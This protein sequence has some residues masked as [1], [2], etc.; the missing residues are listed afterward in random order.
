MDGGYPDGGEQQR[1]GDEAQ[2]FSPLLCESY[3]TEST[4]NSSSE[5]KGEEVSPNERLLAQAG[6]YATNPLGSVIPLIDHRTIL[7]RSTTLPPHRTSSSYPMDKSEMIEKVIRAPMV[8]IPRYLRTNDGKVR[9]EGLQKIMSRLL[10]NDLG[11]NEKKF[12]L[13]ANQMY[14]YGCPSFGV[15][16][17]CLKKM[18]KRCV[19]QNSNISP[20]C[21]I[22]PNSLLKQYKEIHDP[23]GK[24]EF[25]FNQYIGRKIPAQTLSFQFFCQRCENAA[26]KEEQFLVGLY[27]QIMGAK[28]DYRLRL[29]SNDAEKL[30]HIL[31]VIMFRGMLLGVDFFEETPKE[32]FDD[33]FTTLFKLREFC[34]TFD[35][36]RYSD[37]PISKRIQVFLLPNAHFNAG[38]ID[39]TY[40]LD[41]Q[42]RN[43][44]FTTV[45][46]Q[47]G[48]KEAYLY[49]KFDCFHWVL[50]VHESYG[51]FLNQSSCFIIPEENGYCLPRRA[52]GVSL[53]PRFLVNYNIHQIGNLIQV[54]GSDE[55]RKAFGSHETSVC[56]IQDLKRGMNIWHTPP[57]QETEDK[58]EIIVDVDKIDITKMTGK[59]ITEAKK[60][61]P[62]AESMKNMSKY[63]EASRREIKALEE[64]YS[65]D[66]EKW[67]RKNTELRQENDRMKHEYH[68]LKQDY[69]CLLKKQ[70]Q[71]HSSL[72]N[73]EDEEQ[74]YPINDAR[75]MSPTIPVSAPIV[76]H[77]SLNSGWSSSVVGKYYS[78]LV[79]IDRVVG[80]VAI[81]SR[82]TS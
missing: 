65:K 30:K 5:T 54:F 76:S 15:C 40:I 69:E 3:F 77:I 63:L 73:Q 2:K 17:I 36:P 28:D 4:G 53:F 8:T 34:D 61:S 72:D 47:K 19:S 21:H 64:R 75:G 14:R 56:V 6:Q 42:L 82:P 45:I 12:F 46:N 78:S 66:K 16:S 29:S 74:D 35:S 32:Y 43:P 25:I 18:G 60:K 20:R 67:V 48:T 33:L 50:P 51:N 49:T 10:H 22:F 81:S 52:E 31:A 71:P 59:L 27:L 37:S 9:V 7:E 26:S 24:N 55:Y 58:N 39:P 44:L 41:L 62:I 38:N 13:F 70:S 68:Q 11:Q 1:V 80:D 23:A 79:N 57:L